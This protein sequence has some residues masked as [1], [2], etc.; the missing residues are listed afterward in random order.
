MDSELKDIFIGRIIQQKVDEKGM[1]YAEFARRINMAR[2]SLYYLFNAKSIDVERLILISKVLEYDF[3]SEIYRHN[4]SCNNKKETFIHIPIVDG[5]FNIEGLP[6]SLL[7]LLKK[8]IEER[9]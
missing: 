9:T 1:Q 4:N 6:D 5:K 7:Q 3:I 8:E 2:T